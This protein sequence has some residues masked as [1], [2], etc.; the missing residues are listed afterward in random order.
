M[1]FSF[2]GGTRDCW[3]GHLPFTKVRTCD[4]EGDKSLPLGYTVFS[5]LP[6]FKIRTELSSCCMVVRLNSS[7]FKQMAKRIIRFQYAVC[8]GF[9]MFLEDVSTNNYDKN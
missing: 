1:K 6:L 9:I 2:F 7:S 3:G 8:V 5:I 4:N